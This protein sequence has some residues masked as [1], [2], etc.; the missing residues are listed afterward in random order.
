MFVQRV[1]GALFLAISVAGATPPSQAPAQQ[2]KPAPRPVEKIRDG[3]F[4]VGTIEVDTIKKEA[5]VNGVV[6]SD[7]TTLEWVA[8]T[9][10]GA[11]AYE[12]AFTVDT[13]ATTFNAALLL[14]GLDPSHARVPTRHFDPVP[15]QGDAVE[16][17]VE[18]TAGTTPRRVRI[19]Q[20]LYD[21]RTSAP[22]RFGPWVYTGSAFSGGR[23]LA[24]LDGVLIGFVH[25][26]SPVIENPGSG[27]V[28]AFGR[29]TLNN[30]RLGVPAG[31]KVTLV[32][33]S[34]GTVIKG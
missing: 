30:R 20:F 25:S 29:V 32:I 11:K 22:M 3:V 31:Q 23:Y 15:P 16:I 4:R 5:R 10:G 28:D 9:K 24:D 12:S 26:P 27:A 33:R 7:V 1:V 21:E 18:W 34:L 19:E 2:P 17:W 6:N 13:D 14:M 8:N